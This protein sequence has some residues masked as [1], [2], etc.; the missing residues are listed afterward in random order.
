MISTIVG[1]V[2]AT[3]VIIIG[4]LIGALDFRTAV[5]IMKERLEEEENQKRD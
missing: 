1:L 5:E 4:H 2:I 3:L